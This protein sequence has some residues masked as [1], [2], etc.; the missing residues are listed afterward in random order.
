MK[1]LLIKCE[2]NLPT[3]GN[4][5]VLEVTLN[6]LIWDYAFFGNIDT[7]VSISGS[8][9]FLTVKGYFNTDDESIRHL[10]QTI[11]DGID[12]INNWGLLFEGTENT[13]EIYE[14]YDVVLEED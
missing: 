7:W 14:P 10:E 11:L 4:V 9:L 2:T 8:V 5:E 12:A 13:L 3:V 1:K 6:H